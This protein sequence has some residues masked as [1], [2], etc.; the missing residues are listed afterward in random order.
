MAARKNEQGGTYPTG[1]QKF[2]SMLCFIRTTLNTDHKDVWEP[3]TE[4]Y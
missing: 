4:R 2:A 1:R 3:N